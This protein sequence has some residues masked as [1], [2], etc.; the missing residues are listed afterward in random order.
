MWLFVLYVTELQAYGPSDGKR[1]PY[2]PPYGGF[3][4]I[5]MISSHE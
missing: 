5:P 2:I 1:T 3:N 4:I